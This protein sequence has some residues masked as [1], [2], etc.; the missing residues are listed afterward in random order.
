MTRRDNH[1]P[2]HGQAV[3][4]DPPAFKKL[5]FYNNLRHLKAVTK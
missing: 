1:L 3:P 5:N 4:V 2:F